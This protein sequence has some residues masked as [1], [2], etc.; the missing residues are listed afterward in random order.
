MRPIRANPLLAFFTLAYAIS[1]LCWGLNI[2]L[3]STAAQ[4]SIALG[5]FGPTLA[6]LLIT[7][8]IEGGAG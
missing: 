6:A 7:W 8:A 4:P 1:W 5:A 2:A 3:G